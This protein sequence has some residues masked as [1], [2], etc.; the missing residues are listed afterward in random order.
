MEAN[1]PRVPFRAGRR[2]EEMEELAATMR[3]ASLEPVMALAS[4]HM[5]KS[6][7]ALDLRSVY[8]DA[9]EEH[10]DIADIIGIL[11]GR[12]VKGQRD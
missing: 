12:L 4:S 3:M 9:D 1:I 2:S 6:I 11:H 5:L 7:G 8:T 10:W